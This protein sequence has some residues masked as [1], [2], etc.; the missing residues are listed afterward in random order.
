MPHSSQ[1]LPLICA[2]LA[3]A[4]MLAACGEPKRAAAP[5]AAAPAASVPAPA[6]APAPAA[7]APAVPDPDKALASK[8]KAALAG[9]KGVIA[10]LIDVSAKAGKVTL[11]GTVN[12]EKE[13]ARA[14]ALAGSVAGVNAV[15]N[16]LNIVAGS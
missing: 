11:W 7:T 12:N 1:R 16:K 10:H 14:A 8:V 3:A 6:P 5:A 9:D 13:R 4:G 2:V 15:E